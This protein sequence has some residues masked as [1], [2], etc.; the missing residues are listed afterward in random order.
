[1]RLPINK[2]RALSLISEKFAT[3]P[4]KRHTAVSIATILFIG[5]VVSA[6]SL[7]VKLAIELAA[8]VLC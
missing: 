2:N 3:Q 5:V 1:M 6:V 7:V 8:K 4:F